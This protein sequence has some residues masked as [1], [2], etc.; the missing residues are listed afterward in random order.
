MSKNLKK[1]Q[2]TTLLDVCM[3]EKNPNEVAI[4]VR[5]AAKLTPEESSFA[6]DACADMMIQ[7]ETF[8]TAVIAT[9]VAFL[10]KALGLKPEQ[11]PE[12]TQKF[13]DNINAFVRDYK[14]GEVEVRLPDLGNHK[15]IVS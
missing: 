8:G 5:V 3:F 1:P 15:K 6:A 9:Y 7:D 11:G 13:M 12:F 10:S 4:E 14:P 2:K